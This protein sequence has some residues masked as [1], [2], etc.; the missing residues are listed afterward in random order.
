MRKVAVVSRIIIPAFLS[1]SLSL[2]TPVNDDLTLQVLHVLYH[3]AL[4]KDDFCRF[5]VG[6][7]VTVHRFA[8]SLR[9][10]L[11][12]PKTASLGDIYEEL[13]HI[14]G[15]RDI[16][17]ASTKLARHLPQLSHYSLLSRLQASNIAFNHR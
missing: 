8:R 7:D 13:G 3:S 6:S 14:S 11:W 12:E 1:K 5:E 2:I 4:A 16:I 15:H 17:N 9:F 10:I